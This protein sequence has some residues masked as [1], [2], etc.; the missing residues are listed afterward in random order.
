M[1]EAIIEGSVE[2]KDKELC[3]LLRQQNELLKHQN[4]ILSLISDRLRVIGERIWVKK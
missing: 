2:V 1:S 3:E 4:T